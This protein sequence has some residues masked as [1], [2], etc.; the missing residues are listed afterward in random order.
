[1]ERKPH[2]RDMQCKGHIVYQVRGAEIT[3]RLNTRTYSVKHKQRGQ[4]AKDGLIVR[5]AEI[6]DKAEVVMFKVAHEAFKAERAEAQRA[7]RRAKRGR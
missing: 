7:E 4:R 3:E 2:M 6:V 1:M 5:T